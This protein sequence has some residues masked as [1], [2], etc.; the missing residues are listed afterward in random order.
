MILISNPD[1]F[2]PTM[3]PAVTSFRWRSM[4]EGWRVWRS[5]TVTRGRGV[6][7]ELW[8]GRRLGF[9]CCR[10]VGICCCRSSAMSW[11]VLSRCRRR[12]AKRTRLF[13]SCDR[14]G[15]SCPGFV[16]D[17]LTF[18][19]LPTDLNPLTFQLEFLSPVSQLARSHCEHGAP[20]SSVLLSSLKLSLNPQ[21][22]KR[23]TWMQ[24]PYDSIELTMGK[25]KLV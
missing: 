19:Q 15:V 7:V 2:L 23:Y 8:R 6:E 21:F 4:L 14:V 9:R 16:S 20:F 3:T 13:S 22:S 11:A 10:G 17:G 1:S 18:L 25:P 12:V 5:V 24:S